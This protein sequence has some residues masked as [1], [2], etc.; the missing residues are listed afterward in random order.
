MAEAPGV[1]TIEWKKKPLGFSIVMDTTGKNAYVSSIQKEENKTKG[2]KLAAQIITINGHDV[3]NLDHKE[4][5][6]K[7]KSAKLPIKLQF[8]PRS[9][10]NEPQDQNIP[11]PLKFEGA[12]VNQNRINGYFEL[13][14]EKYNGRPQWQRNDALEDPVI[15]WYWPSTQPGN[16]KAKI[17]KDLWMISRRSQRD[18]QNA[19]ACVHSNKDLPTD[20][21]NTKWQCYNQEH[22]GKE[23]MWTDCKIHIVQER[24]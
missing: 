6:G 5:L 7:I 10:A 15:V 21:E 3:K 13:V 2:L 19:Y 11:N 16:I 22:T 20:I 14:K 8:Q 4:I 18:T 17:N 9:F 12:T 23:D 24:Q 1:Y